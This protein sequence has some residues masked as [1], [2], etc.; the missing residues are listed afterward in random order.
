M[1]FKLNLKVLL[2]AEPGFFII[3]RASYHE[4]LLRGLSFSPDFPLIKPKATVT[5]AS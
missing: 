2:W 5:R 1:F 3:K 4:P